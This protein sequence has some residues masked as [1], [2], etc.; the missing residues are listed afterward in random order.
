MPVFFPAKLS[1]VPECQFFSRRSFLVFQKA[2]FF[3]GEAFW[4]VRN[5]PFLFPN[6]STAFLV[7]WAFFKLSLLN[8]EQ[9][10][11]QPLSVLLFFPTS[12]RFGRDYKTPVGI[13]NLSHVIR[14]DTAKKVT[15]PDCRQAEDKPVSKVSSLFKFPILVDCNIMNEIFMMQIT[16]YT[17]IVRFSQK[18]I[19]SMKRSLFITILGL[20]SIGF[21]SCKKSD[22]IENLNTPVPLPISDSMFIISRLETWDGSVCNFT[23]DKIAKRYSNFYFYYRSYNWDSTFIN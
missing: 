1:G 22:I 10:S 17:I 16:I 8:Q 13:Y 6:V 14:R 4:R 2:S 9:L 15:N 18:I 12:R 5:P 21:F 19:G 7:I 20:M 23:Y 3:V 11:L